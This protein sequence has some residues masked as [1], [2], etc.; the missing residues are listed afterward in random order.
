MRERW[1]NVNVW[2]VVMGADYIRYTYTICSVNAGT[3]GN[4]E[5]LTL[6]PDSGVLVRL[7]T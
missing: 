6:E 2:G 1:R 3:C 4:L 5:E 7:V